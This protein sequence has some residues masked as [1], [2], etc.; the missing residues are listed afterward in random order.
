[1]QQPAEWALLPV[2]EYRKRY[3]AVI[4]TKVRAH[5]ALFKLPVA[6]ELWLNIKNTSCDGCIQ[7]SRGIPWHACWPTTSR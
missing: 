2:P 1:M 4:P 6:S 7:P 5:A 3:V